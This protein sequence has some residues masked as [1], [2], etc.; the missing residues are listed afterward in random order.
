M[1]VLDGTLP[2]G[3]GFAPFVAAYGIP[4]LVAWLAPAMDDAARRR[5]GMFAAAAPFLVAM[6]FTTVHPFWLVAGWPY[7][8]LAIVG[9][10]ERTKALLVTEVAWMG[11]I[12]VAHLIAYADYVWAPG[13]VAPMLLPHLF[14]PVDQLGT[15]VKVSGVLAAKGITPLAP[16][17]GAVAIVTSLALLWLLSPWSRHGLDD[18][19]DGIEHHGALLF[20]R[21]L[22]ALALCLPAI[23]CYLLSLSK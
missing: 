15:L 17:V 12:T 10:P 11:P 20:T 14:T 5:W 2:V 16:A 7:L 23:A 4:V 19:D 8:A 3:F 21:T 9:R 6:M 13:T 22:L 18:P 1:K